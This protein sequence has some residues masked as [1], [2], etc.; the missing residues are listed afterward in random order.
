MEISHI[1][2]QFPKQLSTLSQSSGLSNLL[3]L[4]DDKQSIKLKTKMLVEYLDDEQIHSLKTTIKIISHPD[5]YELIFDPC[6]RLYVNSFNVDNK[7]HLSVTSEFLNDLTY[8][9]LHIIQ[10]IVFARI[11]HF[12]Q[13]TYIDQSMS[14]SG[15]DLFH[16]SIARLLTQGDTYYEELGFVGTDPMYQ[17][18]KARYHY[19]ISL[20][21]SEIMNV[22]C[23]HPE[24]I[25]LCC[26]YLDDR[27]HHPVLTINNLR[28]LVNEYVD[29]IHEHPTQSISVI[30]QTLISQDDLYCL[31]INLIFH[32][33]IIFQERLA[34]V[35]KATLDVVQH[36]TLTL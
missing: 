29:L 23:N 2:F 26:H 35:Y 17:T 1:N 10:S 11:L 28:R 15:D 20:P 33:N 34:L 12:D 4:L 19:L 25:D 16:S 6:L 13:M 31:I 7:I 8:D 3:Q 14:T 27:L 18:T 32:T 5:F 22:G 30:N 9:L 24:K 36:L 21:V